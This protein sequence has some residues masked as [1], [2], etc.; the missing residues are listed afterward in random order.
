MS[1]TP[2]YVALPLFITAWGVAVLVVLVAFVIIRD[3]VRGE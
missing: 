1:D 2:W 3:L